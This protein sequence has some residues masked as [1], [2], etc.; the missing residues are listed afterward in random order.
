MI[1]TSERGSEVGVG[2]RLPLAELFTELLVAAE[3]LERGLEDFT[4]DCVSVTIRTRFLVAPTELNLRP[5]GSAGNPAS[6]LA[7]SLST[8][9]RQQRASHSSTIPLTQLLPLSAILE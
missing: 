5:R 7:M 3:E 4:P 8:T 6:G 9:P 1:I 2:R